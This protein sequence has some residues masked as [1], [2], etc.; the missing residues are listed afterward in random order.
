MA[1]MMRSSSPTTAPASSPVGYSPLAAAFDPRPAAT[2]LRPDPL[3][4]EAMLKRHGLRPFEGARVAVS[5]SGNVAQYA[6]RKRW[7]LARWAVTASDSTGTR[8]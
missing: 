2:W 1:G 4:T 6:I 8:R 3:P 7:S 5:R